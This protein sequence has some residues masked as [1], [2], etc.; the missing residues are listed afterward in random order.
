M[1]NWQ[2][3]RL[4]SLSLQEEVIEDLEGRRMEFC[5]AFEKPMSRV[6]EG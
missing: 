2:E 1:K 4:E 5:Q 6:P 3:T